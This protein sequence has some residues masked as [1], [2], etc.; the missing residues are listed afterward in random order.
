[1]LDPAL[2][3]LTSRRRASGALL[4]ALVLPA[5]LSVPALGATGHTARHRPTVRLVRLDPATLHGTGFAPW[6]RVRLALR[7]RGEYVVH[8]RASSAGTFTATFPTVIDRCSG[9]TV[10][11]AQPGTPRLIVHGPRPE[12]APA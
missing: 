7:T 3:R 8:V 6:A 9:W 2:I 10:T 11:A 12:C 5:L 4:V 1:M